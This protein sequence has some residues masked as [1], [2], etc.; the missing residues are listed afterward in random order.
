MLDQQISNL[1]RGTVAKVQQRKK[2]R[3]FVNFCTLIYC[4]WWMKCSAAT[5]APW[6]DV[7]LYQNLLSY[8]DIDSV[9]AESA[10]KAMK[11]HLWYLSAE[12]IP[13]ALFD[14]NVPSDERQLIADKL[15]ML[16]PTGDDFKIHG[17]FGEGFGKP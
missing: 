14:E 13:L 9:V 1:P 10:L 2:L 4:P 11:R 16:R 8:R 15:L 5:E 6:N 12:M 7:V 3:Q 17:R